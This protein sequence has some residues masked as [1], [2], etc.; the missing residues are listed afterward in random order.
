[1]EFFIDYVPT[2]NKR[3]IEKFKG[4]RRRKTLEDVRDL[5]EYAGILADD[6]VMID[7]DDAA[8]ADM[9][10]RIVEDLNVQCRVYQTRRGKHFLFR[11]DAPM[12]NKNGA[13]L[14]VGLVADLKQGSSSY[15]VLKFKGVD[16]E[17]LRDCETA[18]LL[19]KW[20]YPVKTNVEFLKMGEGDGRN[21]A[22]FN[23]IL[24]L[25]SAGL[26]VEETRQ[27]IRLLNKYVLPAP[28]GDDE[29]EIILRDEAFKRPVFF[30]SKDR[31]LFDKFSEYMRNTLHIKR[32]N[33]QLCFYR[34]GIYTTGKLL[35]GHEM[36]KLIPNLTR[37]QREEVL[38]HLEHSIP[39]N[40]AVV[41]H[42]LIAFRNG[43]YNIKTG[44]LLEFSPEHI[45][46][47]RINWDYNPNAY[48]ELLDLT[49]NKIACDD[50]EIR[51]LM[52]E[53]AGYC[54]YPRNELG[55]MFFLTGDTANGKS[56]YLHVLKK[57]LGE[58]NYSTLDP[59]EF[60]RTFL[61]A[62]LFGKLANI[63]DDVSDEFMRD[64]HRLKKF[65]TGEEVTSQKKNKDPFQYGN[66]AKLI[67]SANS[68]PRMGKGKDS[69]A[70][71]RRIM[72]IP[73]NATFSRDDPDYRP[74]I[75]HE[76]CEQQHMEYFILLAIEGLKR[77]LANK[78][79]TESL[80]VERQ[81]DEYEELNNPIIAFFRS[82][83]LHE[84]E[85]HTVDEVYRLYVRYCYDSGFHELNK[86][87]FSK[88]VNRYYDFQTVIKKIQG[89]THRV[90]VRK[91]LI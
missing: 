18:D 32:I 85:N 67:F 49:L 80:Q 33:G 21:Q 70:I 54:F 46:L 16:R 23:Y 28:L 52:E 84:I 82:V 31:F 13:A 74:F 20:L 7:V 81:L 17:I 3:A 87:E 64:T 38:D 63:G 77:V 27:A 66:Y 8:Q 45:I 2:E 72:P 25:T 43:L 86:I 88:Q 26:N 19:P 73:F 78:K 34:D 50:K 55:K 60:N 71:K 15:E 35:I 42:N 37:T 65:V 10:M 75:R 48:S 83:E 68:I 41:S 91:A 76:L 56:T 51:A 47:N 61:D 6:V 5:A 11:C 79:F 1:M 39:E 9:L 90:Y 12:R 40:N 4:R 36:L 53:I 62:E 44:K 59:K 22:L 24:T 58:K 69:A 89:K 30:D 29:L 57:M 14:A